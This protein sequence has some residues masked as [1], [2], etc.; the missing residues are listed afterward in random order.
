MSQEKTPCGW[1]VNPATNRTNS[2]PQFDHLEK[3]IAS[4]VANAHVG[5][6]PHM[7]AGLILAQLTHKHGLVPKGAVTHEPSCIECKRFSGQR[8]AAVSLVLDFGDGAEPTRVVCVW[9]R[10]YRGWALPGGRVEDG[11]TPAQAQARELEEETGML[12][13]NAWLAFSG[14]HNIE[15]AQGAARPGR[16]SLVYLY[17]VEAR[18]EAREVEEGC[19]VERKTVEE[20]LAVSPFAELYRE[21]LPEIVERAT[22]DA[23]RAEGRG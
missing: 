13:E 20:F 2:S 1:D 17:V 19:L 14:E 12:T 23:R 18:G 6:N 10:R 5:D 4:I 9:N 22:R 16:A 21:I 15:S 3:E 8:A 11:E 7:V